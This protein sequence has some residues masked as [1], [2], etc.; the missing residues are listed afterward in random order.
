MVSIFLTFV[1]PILLKAIWDNIPQER[2]NF[3]SHGHFRAANKGEFSAKL[4]YKYL[5]VELRIIAMQNVPLESKKKQT[6]TT[7]QHKGGKGSFRCIVSSKSC[8]RNQF[9]R[10]SFYLV[11]HIFSS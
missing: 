3:L 6:A 9:A 8:T 5:A 7:G 2:L 4:I 1:T 10:T 11:Q